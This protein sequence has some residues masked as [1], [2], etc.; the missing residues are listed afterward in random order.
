MAD[1]MNLFEKIMMEV[2]PAHIG[3]IALWIHR[4]HALAPVPAEIPVLAGPFTLFRP[5]WITLNG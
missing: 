5:D 3:K 1:A 4:Q 2:V